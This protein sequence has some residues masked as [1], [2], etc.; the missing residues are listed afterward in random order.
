MKDIRENYLITVSLKH[1]GDE[2]LDHI[3]DTIWRSALAFTLMIVIARTLGKATVAQMT[4][5]D[6][7]AAITLGALTANLAFNVHMNF[8]Q[9]IIS[10]VTFSGIAYLFMFL[11]L[12]NRTIRKIFSGQPTVLIQDGKI[13]ESNLKKLKTTLD[14][15]N[16]ELRQKNIFNIS[17]VEYAVLELNGKISVLRKAEYLP[18]IH[19][20]LNI[21]SG[22]KQSF[23]V[24]LMMDGKFVDDNF[25][26]NQ[27]SKD[28][29]LEQIR[30]RGLSIDHINYA[31]I[32]TNSQLYVDEYQDNI[33]KPI[34]KE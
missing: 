6:F 27:I 20:D 5:H 23:P 7:V 16:Q 19:K 28:W 24:E 12:K 29:L 2:E 34:D 32:G 22:L 14:T 13:L 17:E 26:Q 10:L 15:L 18:V 21:G 31:V 3:L 9:L 11:A 4:Y 33:Q 25:E 1:I 8:F 30:D